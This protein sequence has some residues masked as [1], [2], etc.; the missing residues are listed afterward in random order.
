MVAT[1]ASGMG[2]DK[3]DIRWI[4]HLALPDSPD[5][6]L[7]EIGRA[8][9]DGEPAH[10]YLLHRGE[11]VALQRYFTGGAPDRATIRDLV[12]LLRHR[13]M[14]HAALR[15]RTGLG[16]RRLSQIVSLLEQT[17]GVIVGADGK[18]RVPPYAPPPLA[19][20]EIALA[21][22][23]RHLAVRRSRIDMMRGY[24]ETRGC[25]TQLLLAYFGEQLSGPCGHCDNCADG[26]ADVEPVTAQHPFPVNSAVNHA[27]WG[28]GLVMGYADDR[29]T[30]LFDDV[31]YKTLSVPV[32]MKQGLLHHRPD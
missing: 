13:P 15:E 29:M 2:I 25:R 26:V 9:R 23:D 14:N 5:S 31:G 32:V 6:Y 24:A 17:G 22:A 21:E 30:V 12:T 16:S 7:Q 1:S 10:T 27:Q 4:V 28:A 3:P 19:A 11:D 18:V 8:G 20:A